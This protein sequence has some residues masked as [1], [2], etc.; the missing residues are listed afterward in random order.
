MREDSGVQ[1]FRYVQPGKRPLA[2]S[3]AG[4]VHVKNEALVAVL[5]S[6]LLAVLLRAED[7]PQWRGPHRDGAW[8]EKRVLKTFPRDGLKVRWRAAVGPGCSSPVVARGRVFLT[9]VQVTRP[10]SKER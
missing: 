9:D 7:W 8:T 6:L 2:L 10:K 1:A 4:K 3:A 5:G